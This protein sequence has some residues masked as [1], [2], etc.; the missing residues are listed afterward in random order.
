MESSKDQYSFSFLSLNL[1]FGLIME[2]EKSSFQNFGKSIIL[3][4]C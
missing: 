4:I 3:E 1:I 2:N